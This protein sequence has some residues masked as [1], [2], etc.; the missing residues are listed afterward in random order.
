MEHCKVFWARINISKLIRI[1][2]VGE[3]WAA[4]CFLYE[5]FDEYDNAVMCM[6]NHVAEA[7]DHRQ[8]TELLS[9]GNNIEI[10]HKAIDFYIEY[11]PMELN[12]MLVFLVSRLDH[13]RVVN[14][15]SRTSNLPLVKSYLEQVQQLNLP[16]INE[17]INEMWIEEG[18]FEQLRESV[19]SYQ[20]FDMI[21]LAAKLQSHEC[22]EFRRIATHLYKKAQRWVQAV[23]L[24]KKDKLYKDAIET[25]ATSQDPTIVD[26]LLKYFVEG[27]EK[28]C[29]AATLFMC[30]DFVHPDLVMELAW[31]N[32]IM[33]FA[34]PYFVQVLGEFK[35][36]K[37]Q[38]LEMGQALT[39][40]MTGAAAPMAGGQ[41]MQ[42]QMMAP[43][44]QAAA[45]QSG[46]FG[47]I[48]Q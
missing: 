34:M 30:Y 28:E 39:G 15:I 32:G 20:N 4:Q 29:F 36:M 1:C 42:Q 7:F 13:I 27:S 19:D 45:P 5:K 44:Q 12:D 31:R 46:G 21:G 2:E 10:C 38:M 43:P 14:Q 16:Q 41:Q 11:S 8:F 6:I 48:A 23:D 18:K 3:H 35:Q 47:F 24:A 22:L 26:D 9:K 33:D 40:L 17:A 25:A 37:I